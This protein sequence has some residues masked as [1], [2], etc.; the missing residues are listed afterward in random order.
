M[1]ARRYR[2]YRF[3]IE[4]LESNVFTDAERDILSDAAEGLLLAKVAEPDEVEEISVQI[5]AVLDELV[6]SGRLRYGTAVELR[7]R[8][9]D[10]GPAD[11]VLLSA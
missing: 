10:C 8:I 2:N 6:A 5:S 9:A 7:A 4:V 11:A 3:V 1:D